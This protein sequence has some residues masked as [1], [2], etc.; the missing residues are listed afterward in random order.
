[1]QGKSSPG[2]GAE[3]MEQAHAAAH[4]FLRWLE[5]LKLVK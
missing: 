5:G 3:T 1:M 2:S 4:F